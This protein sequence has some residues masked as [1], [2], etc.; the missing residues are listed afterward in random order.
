[1]YNKDEPLYGVWCEPINHIGNSQWLKVDP[2][3]YK[4]AEKLVAKYSEANRQWRYTVG[5][6]D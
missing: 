1:M 3:S 2:M 6:L 4:D 5:P